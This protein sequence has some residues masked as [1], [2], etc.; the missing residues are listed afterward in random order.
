VVEAWI[1]HLRKH[2]EKI[3]RPEECRAW[4]EALLAEL[5]AARPRI[6]SWREE[7]KQLHAELGTARRPVYAELRRTSTGTKITPLPARARNKRRTRSG[8]PVAL[9][10]RDGA[11]D[12]RRAAMLRGHNRDENIY[13]PDSLCGYSEVHKRQRAAYDLPTGTRP[14]A[15]KPVRMSGPSNGSPTQSFLHH[16]EQEMDLDTEPYD[17]LEDE[18]EFDE[19]DYLEEERGRLKVQD[20]WSNRLGES[21]LDPGQDDARS[22]L[23]MVHPAFRPNENRIAASALPDPLRVK[24]DRE[25]HANAPKDNRNRAASEWTNCTVYT[26]DPSTSQPDLRDVPPVP[27]VPSVYGN[28]R[29]LSPGSHNNSRIPSSARPVDIPEVSSTGQNGEQSIVGFPP[30][31]DPFVNNRGRP[32]EHTSSSSSKT[33]N[34]PLNWPAPP[35]GPSPSAPRKKPDPKRFLFPE[36]EVGSR[37]SEHQRAYIKD[38]RKMKDCPPEM[39][40]FLDGRPR[41][42]MT[43]RSVGMNSTS[44][45][46]FSAHDGR[47]HSATPAMSAVPSLRSSY[48]STIEESEVH[49][50]ANAPRPATAEDEKGW[51]EAWGVRDDATDL[52]PILPDDSASNVH[53]TR[54]DRS[55][56]VTQFGAFRGKM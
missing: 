56:S 46:S 8:V 35:Q 39:N 53:W 31:A 6:G 48:G 12:Q 21:Q 41:T 43:P 30:Y 17:D 45:R 51:R 34:A 24:K 49:D 36:S 4:S 13:R 38:R 25:P 9:V 29:R 44:R 16:F 28:Y 22:V 32:N 37:L 54:Q 5:R 55:S 20:W 33:K 26:V 40:P 7:Q 11:K 10:D 50:E 2:S 47:R 1:D 52:D 27:R 3:G 18:Q 23:S 42:P 14:G 15:P 19:R